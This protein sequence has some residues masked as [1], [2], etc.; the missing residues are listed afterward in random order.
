MLKTLSVIFGWIFVLVGLLGFFSNPIVGMTGVF[1]TD[2][3]HN[4]V[5]L[6]IGII[7]LVVAYKNEMALASTMKI[8]GI[9]YLLVAVL[10]YFMAPTGGMLLGLMET[11]TADHWL[12]LILGVVLIAISMWA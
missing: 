6:I 2:T 1:Q 4:L 12:H 10:G 8:F 3:M 9:I 5:H 11:N 7:I